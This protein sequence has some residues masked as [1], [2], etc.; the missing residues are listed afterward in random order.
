MR[1]TATDDGMVRTHDDLAALL[2]YA[3]PGARV[4][5][6]RLADDPRPETVRRARRVVLEM[7]RIGGTVSAVDIVSLPVRADAIAR[8]FV[9]LADSTVATFASRA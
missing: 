5:L 3:L 7:E 9:T 6:E 2:R 8:R 1:L 4:R